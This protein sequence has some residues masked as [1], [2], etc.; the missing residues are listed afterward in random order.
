ML[1]SVVPQG[2]ATGVPAMMSALLRFSGPMASGME[3]FVDLHQ[4]GLDWAVVPMSCSFEGTGAP[5][6]RLG[7]QRSTRATP[8]G[9]GHSDGGRFS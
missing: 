1:M 4:G 6:Q 7:P 8:K 5:A 9:D 3:P 2:G